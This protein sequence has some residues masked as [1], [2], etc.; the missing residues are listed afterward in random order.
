MKK[1]VYILLIIGFFF[2]ACKD[3]IG[4]E[5][6]F[7]AAGKN[8][9]REVTVS[10]FQSIIASDRLVLRITQDTAQ[11]QKVVLKGGGNV[12]KNVSVAVDNGQLIIDDR[13]V[14]NW[15]R[16]FSKKIIVEI[17]CKTLHGITLNDASEIEFTDTL[18]SDSLVVYQRS[19]GKVNL[20]VKAGK[21][22]VNHESTGVVDINGYA[23]VFVPVMF[24]AGKL[25]ARNMQGD[26]TFAY[27][28]GINELHVKPFKVLHALVGNSGNIFYYAEPVEEPLKVERIGSGNVERK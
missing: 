7:M 8:G 16:D 24:D 3:K 11:P 23:A 22:E 28:Y 6:C 21:F 9:S 1:H 20:T 26:Y 12:I 4:P 17:N 2:S 15:T 5:E 25:D 13:N 14:C 10:N 27:H 18:Q 19:A